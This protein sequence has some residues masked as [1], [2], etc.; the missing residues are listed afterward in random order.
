MA[1]EI[2]RALISQRTREAL[3]AR[4]QKGLGRTKGLG[5]SKLSYYRAEIEALLARGST[6]K[7][8]AKR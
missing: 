2:D 3:A 5:K 1:V 6:Q 8:V 7:F 4:K